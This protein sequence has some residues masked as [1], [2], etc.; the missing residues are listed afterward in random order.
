MTSVESPEEFY[1]RV[2]AFVEKEPL[3]GRPLDTFLLSFSAVIERHRGTTPSLGDILDWLL[4]ALEKPPLAVSE[5]L[6]HATDPPSLEDSADGFD[7]SQRLIRFQVAEFRRMREKEVEKSQLRYFGV[8]GPSGKYWYNFD[9]ATYLECGAAGLRDLAKG[10]S[11]WYRAHVQPGWRT[12]AAFL[13]L[14]ATYE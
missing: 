12:V 14:G 7:L 5:E 3:S 4:E 1:D 8:K 11:P 6:R 13:E 9:P 2:L 10:D